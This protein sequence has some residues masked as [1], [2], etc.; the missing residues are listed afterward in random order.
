MRI[1]VR[2]YSPD[3]FDG[4]AALSNKV[5]MHS[6]WANYFPRGLNEEG[7]KK[8]FL[9]SEQENPETQTF[10]R[11]AG[12]NEIEGAIIAQTLSSFEP[13]GSTTHEFFRKLGWTDGNSFYQKHIAVDPDCSDKT[14]ALRLFRELKRYA[15][16]RGF[17]RLIVGVPPTN[18]R[19]LGLVSGL[20]Y[21]ESFTEESNHSNRGYP[22]TFFLQELTTP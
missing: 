1:C 4:L 21:R 20:R 10:L 18:T 14:L 16:D 9:L 8:E 6:D 22:L 13:E 2:T 17:S 7:L 3:D 11:V 5:I 12:E 15:H 19:G